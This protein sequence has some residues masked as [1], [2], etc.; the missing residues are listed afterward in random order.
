MSENPKIEDLLWYELVHAKFWE[1]YLAEYTTYKQDYRK[2]YNIITMIFSV[3]GAS[4]FPLWKLCS[5]IEE[6]IPSIVFG[7]MAILQ[8]LAIFQKNLSSTNEELMNMIKLRG[9]YIHYFNKL[10]CLYLKTFKEYDE[11]QLIEEYYTLRD[12][13]DKIEALKD[14]LN[15]HPN[16]RSLKKGEQEARSYVEIR[17]N[18]V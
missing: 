8:I 9:M 16:K 18:A 14:S 15:I 5:S 11:G 4:T 10:E 3:I 7:I 1:Q 6:Y 13:T 12:S 17:F 2:I